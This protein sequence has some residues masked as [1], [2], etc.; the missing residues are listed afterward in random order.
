[1]GKYVDKT[2]KG[3]MYKTRMSGVEKL[4]ACIYIIVTG[5]RRPCPPGKG[6]TVREVGRRR[7]ESAIV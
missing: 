1:M 4:E 6:C 3:C 7:K 5:K 2:C